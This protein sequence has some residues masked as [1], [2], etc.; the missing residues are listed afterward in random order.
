[1]EGWKDRSDVRDQPFVPL[2]VNR[3]LNHD[4]SIGTLS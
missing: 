2:V 3:L 4:Q 1:M